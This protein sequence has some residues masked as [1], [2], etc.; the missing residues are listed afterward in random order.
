[1]ETAMRV[2]ALPVGEMDSA[3]VKGEFQAIAAALR[4]LGAEVLELDAVADK[5]AARKAV[6]AMAG[7]G[8]ELLLLVALRGLSAPICEAA[9][10]ACLTPTL[11]WPVQGRFGLPSSALAVGALLQAGRRAELIHAPPDNP[12]AI[13]SAL[14]V[15]RAA[16]ALARLSR[17]R[18]ATVGGLFP[19]LVSCRYDA[20]ALKSHLGA[21]VVAV[22][23]DTVR[24]AM[25]GASLQEVSDLRDRVLASCSGGGTVADALEPGLRLHLGLKRIA[26][27]HGLDGFAAECWTGLPAALGLNPC[28]GFIEDSYE[29]ACEGD[30][31]VCVALVA[32]RGLT[33]CSAY[34][35]DLFDCDL[36]GVITLVHCGGSASLA[37]GPRSGDPGAVALGLSS[38]ARQQG[39]QTVTCRPAVR[40]GPATLLRLY[41]AACDTLHV[42]QADIVGCDTSTD[43]KVRARLRGDRWEFL[44][45]CQGNHYI[46][47][48]GDI[49]EELG[50]LARWCGI[51]I[52]ET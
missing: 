17:C 39:F 35:G 48:A 46:A 27:D 42:A 45:R 49:R 38:K 11:F 36:D 1:M 32:L 24:T 19:N 14:S 21:T 33:G 12:K 28:L 30:V 7:N 22:S 6:G 51:A 50:L 2:A 34:V 13:R 8:C 18:V 15:L 43:L 29:L 40:P 44:R 3:Q 26:R 4:G 16:R 10:L 20:E 25:E 52:H 31:Q 47:A 23:Y 41:G 9:G 5:A 37:T